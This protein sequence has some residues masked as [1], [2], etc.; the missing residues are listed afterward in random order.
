MM[1]KKKV[2]RKNKC[3][4]TALAL[5]LI[6]SMGIVS[7]N[8]GTES[9]SC[10]AAKKHQ[11][12]AGDFVSMYGIDYGVGKEKVYKRYNFNMKEGQVF[13]IKFEKHNQPKSSDF[14]AGL[15][16]E[17]GNRISVRLKVGVDGKKTK[18][19]TI[20]VSQSG[21]YHFFFCPKKANYKDGSVGFGF[22]VGI[23]KDS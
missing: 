14:E 8:M 9:V 12:Y 20:T 3:F 16:D 22:H 15:I 23:K 18:T 1:V 21:T 7:F 10:Q 19:K 6:V 4:N 17:A 11:M 5:I 13:K 2:F